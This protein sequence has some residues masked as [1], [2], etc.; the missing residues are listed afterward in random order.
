MPCKIFFLCGWLL[1]PGL[2][3]HA[4]FSPHDPLGENFYPV[5]LVLRS[6]DAIGVS[7]DQSAFLRQQTQQV[8][9]RL[10]ALQQKLKKESE[11]LSALSKKERVDEPTVLAQLD[12]V[13]N[14]E[15]DIKRTQLELLIQIKNQ[16]TPEQQARLRE[17]KGRTPEFQEKMRRLGEVMQKWRKEGRNLFTLEPSR[18]EIEQLIAQKKF[19]EAE[20]AL[21]RILK[22]LAPT[23]IKTKAK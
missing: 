7:K 19:T 12:V 5:E 11:V 3:L 21:D 1:L 16:L 20:A 15:R 10:V 9:G 6:G 22:D 4:Q 17:L 2:A 18:R 14:I 8:K 23:D 13:L